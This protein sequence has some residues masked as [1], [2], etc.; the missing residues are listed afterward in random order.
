MKKNELNEKIAFGTPLG[1]LFEFSPG[2]DCEIFKAD[3]FEPTDEIL[4]IPDLALNNI[5]EYVDYIDEYETAWITQNI[6]D[7]C[8]TGN[9]FIDLCD[10]NVEKAVRL[11]WY[12][13]WQHPSSALD[14][15]DDDEDETP[16]KKPVVV[17]TN[18]DGYL[19]ADGEIAVFSDEPQ[20]QCYMKRLKRKGVKVK[21]RGYSYSIGICKK[22]GSP[23]FPSDLEERGYVSQCFSCDEDFYGFEQK[24]EGC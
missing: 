21:F 11:F 10:G 14:E 12:C 15:I 20:A 22:C 9:D 19:T 23:L 13:D 18:G 3:H 4:Y 24:T 16:E 8:Y 2:Q 17:R 1:Q 5:D 6:L 7:C